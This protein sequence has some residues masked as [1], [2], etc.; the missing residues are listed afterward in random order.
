MGKIISFEDCKKQYQN[1]MSNKLLKMYPDMLSQE[2]WDVLRDCA[3]ADFVDKIVEGALL[4]AKTNQFMFPIQNPG[5]KLIRD[6]FLDYAKFCTENANE[7]ERYQKGITKLKRKLLRGGHPKK[8][9][10]LEFFN[11]YQKFGKYITEDVQ[12][13]DYAIYFVLDKFS[14]Y[15]D[16][17]VKLKLNR[18]NGL[19][20]GLNAGEFVDEWICLYNFY[21]LLGFAEAKDECVSKMADAG[22]EMAIEAVED[23][24]DL[25]GF[26]GIY[27]NDFLNDMF[28]VNEFD[29]I[30]GKIKDK[31]N[32][33]GKIIKFKPKERSEE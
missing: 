32:D 24:I 26:A 7:F 4:S 5:E 8:T 1:S 31:N 6:F 18:M 12:P 27:V 28:S 22:D 17:A 30:N 14:P 9:E 3:Y 11:I 21:D 33:S 23:G 19:I 2:S 13:V 15:V 25:Y 29:I 10:E 16:T 20:D